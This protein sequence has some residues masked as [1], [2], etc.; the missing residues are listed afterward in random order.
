MRMQT[1]L[2]QWWYTLFFRWLENKSP[3]ALQHKLRLNN[4][5]ILPTATGWMFL[6]LAGLVWLL[7]TNYQNN[8][9]LAL[10]YLQFSLFVVVILHTYN[11]LAGLQ[12][13]FFS[14]EPGFAGEPINYELDLLTANRAGSDNILLKWLA[15]ES[16][17]VNLEPLT[18]TRVRLPFS[19][20]RRGRVNPGHLLLRSQYPL[21]IVRCWT[22]LKFD[23]EAVVYPAPRA[24]RYDGFAS[25]V[26]RPEASVQSTDGTGELWGFKNYTQGDSLKRISWKHYAREQGLVTKVTAT[27]RPSDLWLDWQ[28][29]YRGDPELCLSHLCY[30]AL[31]CAAGERPFGL[32]LPGVEVAVGQGQAHLH[33]VLT[34]LADHGQ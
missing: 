10:S 32:R 5:Y 26:E 20:A 2:S 33:E 6:L 22:Y 9:I 29:L 16:R 13:R 21:S 24:C 31:Q 3:A 14:A 23:A 19:S 4:L 28:D 27:S 25:N 18:N 7:G 8:L 15:G 1:A 12:V 30:W 34:A 17:V 11:N